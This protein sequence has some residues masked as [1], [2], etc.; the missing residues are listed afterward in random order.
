MEELEVG[1]KPV[2]DPERGRKHPV[3]EIAAGRRN[4]NCFDHRILRREFRGLQGQGQRPARSSPCLGSADPDPIPCHRV[5]EA[6]ALP[7]PQLRLPFLFSPE[8]GPSEI[9]QLA[10]ALSS[11]VGALETA[12]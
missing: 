10:S 11:A 4:Q 2:C 7:L 3:I 12:A 6:E 5:T 1:A 8:L 9:D